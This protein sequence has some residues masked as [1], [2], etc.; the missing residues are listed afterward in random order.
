M[1]SLKQPAHERH[2]LDSRLIADT[3]PEGV[4]TEAHAAVLF[5]IPMTPPV[6]PPAPSFLDRVQPA[7]D[8]QRPSRERWQS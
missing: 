7:G 8:D 5:G 1:T 2:L 3:Q 4:D 6:A